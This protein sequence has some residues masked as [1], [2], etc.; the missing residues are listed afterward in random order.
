MTF[1]IRELLLVTMVVALALGWWV[2]RSKLADEVRRLRSPP[3]T[4]IDGPPPYW[5][6]RPQTDRN[7]PKP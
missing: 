5:G 2:D 1:F 7:P 6:F 4:E 3:L